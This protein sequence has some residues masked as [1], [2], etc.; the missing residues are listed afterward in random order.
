MKLYVDSIQWK[1]IITGLS[2]YIYLKS[3]GGMTCSLLCGKPVCPSCVI[4]FNNS[5]IRS[6]ILNNNIFWCDVKAGYD[7]ITE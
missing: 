5:R 6:I 1:Q 2:N 3:S 7:S 4:M